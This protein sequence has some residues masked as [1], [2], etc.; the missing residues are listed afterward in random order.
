[1][2]SVVHIKVKKITELSVVKNK[3]VAAPFLLVTDENDREKMNN[4][5]AEVTRPLLNI[6]NW[7]ILV[8]IHKKC[9]K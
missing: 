3:M 5:C 4:E 7:F 8:H 6:A 2:L 1:M 9:R